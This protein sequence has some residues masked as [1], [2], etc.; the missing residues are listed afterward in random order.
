MCHNPRLGHLRWPTLEALSG[1]F[2]LNRL[3][4]GD[5]M[6]GAW[7]RTVTLRVGYS[8]TEILGHDPYLLSVLDHEM[9]YPTQVASA[10]DAGV[11]LCDAEGAPITWD[12]WIRLL[13]IRKTS[14]ASFPTGLLDIAQRLIRKYG[15]PLITEDQRVRPEP[16]VPEPPCFT[17]RPYQ[18]DAV[19]A[20]VRMGHG[21]IV[22]PPRAG[23][24]RLA[25][26]LHR[27]LALPTAW[28]VPTDRIAKQTLA[29]AEEAFGKH[30]ATHLVG[31][32][33]A[34]QAA[35]AKLHFVVATA[36]TA[37]GLGEAFW[38]SRKV[39]IIDEFHHSS[40][41]SYR[42]IAMVKCAHIFHRYGMTGTHYRSGD[43]AMAMHAILSNVIYEISSADLRDKGHLV[44]TDVLFVPVTSPKLRVPGSDKTFISGHGKHGI[45]QHDHRNDLVA[46]AAALLAK[47][48]KKVLVLVG[49]KAQGYR[50]LDFLRPLLGEKVRGAE[51]EKAEFVS[52]DMHRHRLDRILDSYVSLPDEIQIL[53]GTSLVGEGVDLPTADALVYARGESAKVGLMQSAYRVCT[54]VEG[55]ERA[56]VVDFADRHHRK[57]MQHS[58]ERLKV[59]HE[60]SLFHPRVL[61]GMADFVRYLDGEGEILSGAR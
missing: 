47:R 42:D 52:T 53:L 27:Q 19:R 59:Y 26:E 41:K 36:A 29:V 50:I 16:G 15:Y 14:P 6:Q 24:T 37:V 31:G 20:A 46:H 18:A 1:L 39:L 4:E 3:A 9:R 11:D 5:G 60:E 22:A 7:D 44:P 8:W 49:T 25:M 13:R 2:F 33:E 38:S 57:L 48:G 56:V 30:Y 34:D 12:G 54:A 45:H 21:V 55:K 58:L 51:F 17:L 10:R 40:A 32:R 28:I 43:D 35:A 61:D 23:K